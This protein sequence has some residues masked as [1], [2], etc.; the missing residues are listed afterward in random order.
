MSRASTRG[1]YCLR[2]SSFTYS[3][4][5]TSIR[6]DLHTL[7]ACSTVRSVAPSL[8]IRKRPDRNGLPSA[9]ILTLT[10]TLTSRNIPSNP[11][12]PTTAAC[13]SRPSSSPPSQ[14]SRQPS[15]AL[16]PP[17]PSARQSSSLTSSCLTATY[18]SAPCQASRA[19]CRRCRGTATNAV[20][21]EYLNTDACNDPH[22]R[23]TVAIPSSM[24]NLVQAADSDPLTANANC[25]LY[26]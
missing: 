21:R 9:P 12:D 5:V 20:T 17:D 15:P 23:D 7:F 4:E 24:G 16:C 25:Y 2:L 19:M 18:A 22:Y 3:L 26:R 8:T 10:P 6:F 13:C 11:P 1:R 14:A